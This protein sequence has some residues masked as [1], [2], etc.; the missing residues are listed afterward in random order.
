[1]AHVI[2]FKIKQLILMIHIF[3][4]IKIK[5]AC[6]GIFVLQKALKEQAFALGKQMQFELGPLS[7]EL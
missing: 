1:M 7:F 4:S 3:F 5:K 6:L 2:Y